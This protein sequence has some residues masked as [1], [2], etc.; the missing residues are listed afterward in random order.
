MHSWII[1]LVMGILPMV[2]SAQDTGLKRLDTTDSGRQ[3]MAVGRLNI[4]GA[5]FCT[6][7]LISPTLVLT[8]AHCLYDKAT[9][10]RID[11][12]RI[13]FLA[14]WRLGHAS[15]YR[16][17]RQTVAHPDYE[18]QRDATQNRVRND[19]GLIE[20]WQPIRNTSVIPFETGRHPGLDEIVGVVSYAQ[21]RAEAPSLQEVC[22]VIADQ[23]GILILSCDVNLGS[24]GSP[25]FSLD[26]DQPR[27]V[28]VVAAMAELDGKRV[29]LGS[30]LEDSLDV[31]HS[32]LAAGRGLV[33]GQ[34][35]GA[36]GKSVG[37]RFLK[38]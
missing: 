2:A 26:G 37:A 10:K 9:R 23:S 19:V 1:A 18:F 14:G 30:A 13:E 27:I 29:A 6:G 8:A 5:G 22:S 20:L 28:S 36:G 15:A 34:D 4:D 35:A 21:D 12:S 32:E 24:S 11:P 31:L 16:M 38:P 17:A 33:S 7:A 25:V 3:W